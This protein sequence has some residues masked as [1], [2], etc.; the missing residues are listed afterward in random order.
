M[1]YSK[2]RAK[3]QASGKACE[4]FPRLID[5]RGKLTEKSS[6]GSSIFVFLINRISST[7][8]S[9]DIWKFFN[10]NAIIHRWRL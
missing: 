4:D 5:R 9:R 10:A 8:L 2:E 6:G 3:T 1:C 7:S